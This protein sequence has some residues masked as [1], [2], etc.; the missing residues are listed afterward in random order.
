MRDFA[1]NLAVR[2]Y[3]PSASYDGPLRYADRKGPMFS[4]TQGRAALALSR[5]HVESAVQNAGYAQPPPVVKENPP[6]PFSL[7]AAPRIPGHHVEAGG[8][9]GTAGLRHW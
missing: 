6:S 4:E 3:P 8:A 7:G 9:T 2:F 5:S 1:A